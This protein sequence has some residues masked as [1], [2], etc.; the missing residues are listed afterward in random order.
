M[1][2]PEFLEDAHERELEI[3]AAELRVRQLNASI[4]PE[5]RVPDREE[6]PA[7][8]QLPAPAQG[9]LPEL[10]QAGRPALDALPL[11][12]DRRCRSGARAGHAEAERSKDVRH[13]DGATLRP[14]RQ[15]VARKQA[16]CVREE[17]AGHARRLQRGATDLQTDRK[18]PQ[19]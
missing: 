13:A 8:P 12:R 3:K 10:R 4:L 7:L 15:P 9:S 16:A 11:L 5:L 19:P 14:K 1:R 17:R 6:L 18:E 2:P